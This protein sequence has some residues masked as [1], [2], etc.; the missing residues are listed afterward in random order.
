[1]GQMMGRLLGKMGYRPLAV[2]MGLL[3]GSMLYAFFLQH[4]TEEAYDV[5]QFQL[6]DE[7]IRSAKTVEDP[8]R[9]EIEREQAAAAV[10]PSYTFKEELA[11]NQSAVIESL[12]TYILEAKEPDPENLEMKGVSGTQ[13]S[14]LQEQLRKLETENEELKLTDNMLTALLGQPESALIDVR[15]ALQR[16]VIRTLEQPVRDSGLGNARDAAER[17]IRENGGIPSAIIPA[18]V[19]IVRASIIPNETVNEELTEAQREQARLS[20]EP[21]RILQGQVLVQEGQVIDR[22]VYRLLEL[23]GL[24]E[25]RDTLL[26][27]AGLLLFVLL[28]TWLVLLSVNRTKKSD[29][30]KVDSLFVIATVLLLSLAIMQVISL[31]EGEF[32]VNI[33]FLFPAALSGMLT[34][35][36]T[37]ERT[38][39]LI[40]A[41]TASGAGLMLASGFSG[42]LQTHIMLYVLFS[43]MAAIYLLRPEDRGGRLLQKSMAVSAANVLFVGFYLLVNQSQHAAPEVLFY[44]G[45][46]VASGLLS[47]ALAVGLLPFYESAFGI[48]ST[49][50]LVELSNP[51]HP[52]LR[53]IL[54]E[55]PGTYHHSVMV[56]NLADSACE[57]IGANGLLARVG[58]YYHD[59]GKTKHPAFFIENQLNIQNPHDFLKP[60]KSRDI[61]LAHSPDG[62]ATL[63]EH[64]MP[65]EIVDIAAQHH[66][67]SLLKFFYYK[68]MEQNPDVQEAEYRY[69]GPKPQT[70]ET[71]VISLADSVEAAVRSMKE[72]S[73]D[74]IRSLVDAIVEDKVKDGQLDD[75]D[76][77][78]HE[79]KTIKR[80]FC[81][82]LNGIFHSR[83]EYPKN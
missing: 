62:A 60:E 44:I 27:K 1:M 63:K 43:G 11:G 35:L 61:I 64:R 33:A 36:L 39:V 3:I 21:T 15:E 79:L 58:S 4:L 20:V 18:A 41:I 66:G 2:L 47:G 31:V 38:A 72:P 74:K 81:E 45:A 8:V 24:T 59:I 9:T 71:A 82:T 6:A 46:A 10:P 55:T 51:N 69:I 65:Q 28:L 70:R 19:E 34:V 25:E 78:L 52:L 37:E 50:R 26:P 12:F 49:L 77:T 75:C 68:A 14:S 67:T 80:V 54:T 30:Q 22:E 57:E 73:P 83:I 23:A 29:R 17:S 48:L 16:T 13:V 7:T 5:E 76:L 32:D 53:K 56:A 42:L 40:T